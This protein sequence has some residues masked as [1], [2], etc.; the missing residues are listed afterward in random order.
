M[1]PYHVTAAPFCQALLE[2]SQN[3][4]YLLKKGSEH[5]EVFYAIESLTRSHTLISNTHMVFG[6]LYML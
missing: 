2:F 6:N 4:G 5:I 3:P 1:S